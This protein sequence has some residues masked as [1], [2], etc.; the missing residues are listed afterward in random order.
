M[1][2]HNQISN[3]SCCQY[4]SFKSRQH[5]RFYS[6]LNH[7]Y[8]FIK[9]KADCL[10][11]HL[12]TIS[13]NVF[14][15]QS[16]GKNWVLWDE[17]FWVWVYFAYRFNSIRIRFHSGMKVSETISVV[18]WMCVTQVW[19]ATTVSVENSHFPG[20]GKGIGLV[21]HL[22]I[23]ANNTHKKIPKMLGV[24]SGVPI[25]QEKPGST[26]NGKATC[27]PPDSWCRVLRPPSE[28]RH[29]NPRNIRF[30]VSPK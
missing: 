21:S 23:K 20:F 8:S 25:C 19:C 29:S 7:G 30:F 17:H 10:K 12:G 4:I 1:E 6:Q 18:Y 24:D 13:N 16:G 14:R 9:E 26:W 5:R 22:Y 3:I 15:N 27:S 2:L 11:P 28:I